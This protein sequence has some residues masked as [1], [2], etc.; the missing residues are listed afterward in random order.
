[1]VLLVTSM[2]LSS[3]SILTDCDGLIDTAHFHISH[4]WL[5]F[6]CCNIGH[7]PL[8]PL[9]FVCLITPTR[10]DMGHT[11]SSVSCRPARCWVPHYVTNAISYVVT[12]EKKSCSS[13]AYRK[14]SHGTACP[15]SLGALCCTCISCN[16]N[17]LTGKHIHSRSSGV[18]E[19]NNELAAITHIWGSQWWNPC[20]TEGPLSRAATS[21]LIQTK[22]P[23][24]AS[25]WT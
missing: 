18:P 22:W 25:P 5:R 21:V 6:C 3:K 8:P 14:E 15:Q 11:G 4:L 2:S 20:S 7:S 1:M 13:S 9:P 17:N 12:R 19:Q 24:M 23:S 10:T 16:N